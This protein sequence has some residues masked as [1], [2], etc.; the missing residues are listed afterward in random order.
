MGTMQPDS[1][2]SHPEIIQRGPPQS[3]APTPLSW[4]VAIG[5]VVLVL[6]AIASTAHLLFGSSEAVARAQAGMGIFAFIGIVAVFSTNLQAINWRTIGW[7]FALQVLLALFILKFD[8]FGYRPGYEL[9]SLLASVAKKFLEFTDAG[10]RFVFGNL[11]DPAVMEPTFRNPNLVGHA[12]GAPY[13]VVA[14]RD[15][16]THAIGFVFAIRALPTIVFISSFFSVLY[17]FGIL[18]RVVRVMAWG[19]RYLMQTSG[20]ETLSVTANVVMG[21]TE[22]PLIV[23]PFVAGMTESEL[24]ALM[25]GGMAHI[26]GGLMAVYIGLGADPVA[27]LATSVMASPCSLYLTKLMLPETGKP[28]TSGVSQ[29]TVDKTHTSA[30]DA[31]AGGASDGMRLAINIAAMLIAFIAFIALFNYVLGQAAAG[32]NSV[33]GT[34]IELTLANIFSTIFAPAAFLMG[35][36]VNDVPKI[37]DLLGTKLVANEFVAYVDYQKYYD[38]LSPRSRILATYA[39]TGFANFASIGI[40]LGGIGAMAPSRRADLARL[41]GRALLT[42]FLVTLVNAAIAGLLL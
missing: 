12:L 25:V 29:Y 31:A 36:E 26:S 40:Q 4:R 39:L 23:K 18:Q 11:A 8:V 33:F 21:Q 14:A 17:Y 9:F 30:V 34:H 1:T 5:A 15:Q 13:T 20:A 38:S 24:L 7:G 19:M 32:I 6:T 37:A 10:S 22:A 27:I 41:G 42:G 35:V 3:H 16:Q 2:D 28:V